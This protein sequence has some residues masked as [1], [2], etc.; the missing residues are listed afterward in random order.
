[1]SA[2]TLLKSN[3]IREELLPAVQT[4]TTFVP[5]SAGTGAK[6]GLDV[7]GFIG[8][9][10]RVDNTT[11]RIEMKVS[12]GPTGTSKDVLRGQPSGQVLLGDAT[13]TGSGKIVASGASGTSPIFNRLYDPVIEN[14]AYTWTASVSATNPTVNQAFSFPV[15]GMYALS[16]KITIPAGVT[17]PTKA[18]TYYVENDFTKT[19]I[20]TTTN[21]IAPGSL[22]TVADS[23]APAPL[24]FNYLHFGY[25]QR[26]NFHNFVIQSFDPSWTGYVDVTVSWSQMC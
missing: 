7:P 11:G 5:S 20:P 3:K 25:L 12:T 17:I 6:V 22:I 26:F 14:F 15:T 4:S 13:N 24:F 2:N 18:L 21:T 23:G 9:G 10:M 16:V 1:M 8:G 19:V